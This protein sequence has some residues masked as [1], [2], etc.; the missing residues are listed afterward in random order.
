METPQ[1]AAAT[2]APPAPPTQPSEISAAVTP[3]A[4]AAPRSTPPAALDTTYTEATQQSSLPVAWQQ[5][6][7]T[8]RP[9]DPPAPAPAVTPPTTDQAP[10]SPHPADQPPPSTLPEQ[11]K[12]PAS[13]LRDPSLEGLLEAHACPAKRHDSKKTNLCAQLGI[14]ASQ[15][16]LGRVGG[17]LAGHIG[18]NRYVAGLAEDG[19]SKCQSIL[20]RAYLAPGEP[21]IG[22]RAP[23]VRHGHSRKTKWYHIECI[24]ASFRRTCKKSKTITSVADLE[25]FESLLPSDQQKVRDLIVQHNEERGQRTPA[26]RRAEKKTRSPKKVGRA[27]TK[28][29]DPELP[30]PRRSGRT[31]PRSYDDKAWEERSPSPP[32]EGASLLLGLCASPAESDSEDSECSVSRAE[33]SVADAVASLAAARAPQPALKLPPATLAAAGR[34]AADAAEAAVLAA[35]AGADPARAARA[36][37][38]AFEQAFSAIA[39]RGDLLFEPVS[40]GSSVADSSS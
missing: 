18:E 22:K 30:P 16:S 36:G 10:T 24:F 12:R 1:A 39:A 7:L 37:A 21:R 23:S 9:R 17:K 34:A 31:A 26:A 29:L 14:E 19:R 13:E 2:P 27:A 5:A 35:Y 8:E 40:G 4:A 11:K 33:A 20:C 25:G 28:K 3:F 32:E 6:G 15:Q 38:A